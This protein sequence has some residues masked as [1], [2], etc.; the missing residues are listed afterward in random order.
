MDPRVD[1]KTKKRRS[2]LLRDL[3][4]KLSRDFISQ[5]LGK[6]LRVLV[7]ERRDPATGLL[8]G[9]TDNYIRVLLE[10][11]EELKNKLI[12]VRLTEV[13]DGRAMAYCR[14]NPTATNRKCSDAIYG[15]LA[16]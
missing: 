12:G 7:E 14:M 2:K 11:E 6:T 8:T 10:G 13:K 5:F 1:E 3:A 9:Y 16:K 15:T 4:K